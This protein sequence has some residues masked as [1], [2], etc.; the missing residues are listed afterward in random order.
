MNFKSNSLGALL[1]L[2]LLPLLAV[3]QSDEEVSTDPPISHPWAESFEAP[4]KISSERILLEP[5]KPI[6]TEL[7][8]KAVASSKEHLRKTLQWGSWP[9]TDMSEADNRVALENHWEEF[10]NHEAYAYTVLA[11]N[12][13]T[14]LGCVYLYPVPSNKRALSL[15]FWVTEDQL[16]QSLDKHLI[17]IVIDHVKQIW[18]VDFVEFPIPIQNERG[19]QI[20]NEI[21][22]EVSNEGASQSTFLWSR[23]D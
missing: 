2:N 8:F 22:L 13:K 3:G 21:G 15:I 10:K 19:I 12:G 9:P 6:H 4:T 16:K 18:P 17:E 1:F 20:L 11:P 23:D 5:L 14:C 7:D